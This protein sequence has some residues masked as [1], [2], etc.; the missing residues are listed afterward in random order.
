MTTLE[1]GRKVVRGLRQGVVPLVV[2]A[3]LAGALGHVLAAPPPAHDMAAHGGPGMHRGGPMGMQG[4][5]MMSGRMLRHMLDEVK[6][7]DDQRKRVEAIAEAAAK[8]LRAQRDQGRTLREQ[9]MA[10]FTQPT[11]D[12]AAVEALRQ[13]QL[14]QHDQA[15]RRMSQA[16]LDIAAVLTP[17]QRQRLGERM[18]ERRAMFERHHRERSGFEGRSGS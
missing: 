6:A 15:T 13:Q 1:M 16:M 4:G 10:L 7:T 2:A 12:A 14:Q 9:S 5:P 17:E 11:V 3:S 18:K 8:D